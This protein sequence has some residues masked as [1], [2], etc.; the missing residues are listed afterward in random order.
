MKKYDVNFKID[1]IQE[2]WLTLSDKGFLCF[3]KITNVSVKSKKK[4]NNM[5]F[6]SRAR[7]E[8]AL[9]R[10]EDTLKYMNTIPLGTNPQRM[11]AFDF[12]DFVNCE[13]VV[14][15]CIE[16]LGHIFGCE[17]DISKLKQKNDIFKRNGTDNDFVKYVRSLASVHPLDTSR[18]PDYNG[19]ENFHCSPRTYWD[20]TSQDGKDITITIYDSANKQN[21][22]EFLRVSINDFVS[23]LQRWIDLLDIIAIAVKDYERESIEEYKRSVMKTPSDF[24]CYTDYIKY[25]KEEYI[26]RGNDTQWDCFDDFVKI[27]GTSIT[28]LENKAK[29]EL[30]QNAIKLALSFLH[31]RTQNMEYG[32]GYSTGIFRDEDI[33]YTELFIEV[34]N[35]VNVGVNHNDLKYCLEKLFVC[36]DDYRNRME[37]IKPWVNQYVK[38]DNTESYDETYV[39]VTTAL[40][41]ESLKREN[42]LNWNIPN[43]KKYRWSL[44]E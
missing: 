42:V 13:V 27:F 18:H 28:N 1:K 41:L 19:Y 32:K 6:N 20:S 39:L 10:I 25:L 26:R 44:L 31:K 14:I 36:S 38:F 2:L 37:E 11:Q 3:D 23:F 43:E 24:E 33:N 4:Q 29:V 7:I 21:E 22:L 35:P 17:S 34:H 30:Y 12:Y 15:D 9:Y 8:T 16:M 40:Y 5:P